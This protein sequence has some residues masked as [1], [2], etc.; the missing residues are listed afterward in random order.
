MPTRNEAF[1]L[2]YQ[3]AAAAG[4]PAIGTRHNA[5]PEIVLDGETGLLVSVGDT[6]ALAGAMTALIGSAPLRERLGRRARE[7]IERSA[8]PQ[9]YLDKLTGIVIDACGP[10]RHQPN[11]AP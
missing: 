10:R 5:V 8:S 9:Q 3:E 7:V 11:P 6:V 1:G 4:L 2:V